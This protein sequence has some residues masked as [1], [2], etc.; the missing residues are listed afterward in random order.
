MT[1]RGSSLKQHI[2]CFNNIP[3]SEI[4]ARGEDQSYVIWLTEH[5][6]SKCGI[7]WYDTIKFTAEQFFQNP[8]GIPWLGRMQC[9][10]IVERIIILCNQNKR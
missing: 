6:Y 2:C 4:Q 5:A 7:L 8:S 3:L 10:P 9:F 1:G